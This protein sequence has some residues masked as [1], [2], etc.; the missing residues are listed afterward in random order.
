MPHGLGEFDGLRAGA[1]FIGAE[2][3]E[4]IRHGVK[5]RA[6][7]ACRQLGFPPLEMGELEIAQRRAARS[8]GALD[9]VLRAWALALPP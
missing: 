6:V 4:I 1:I 5:E 7:F 2:I 9:C 8:K 3:V